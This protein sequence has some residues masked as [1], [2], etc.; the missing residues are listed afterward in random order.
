ME[1]IDAIEIR[2][3]KV[4]PSRLLHSESV[5]TNELTR[6]RT[7]DGRDQTVTAYLLL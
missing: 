7:S 4:A 6:T 5:T 2:W 1:L 3:A